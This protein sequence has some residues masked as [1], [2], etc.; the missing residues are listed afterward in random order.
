MYLVEEFNIEKEY[1]KLVVFGTARCFGGDSGEMTTNICFFH[2]AQR[3]SAGTV[4]EDMP[5]N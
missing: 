5:G 2:S 4:L 1:V 3:Y